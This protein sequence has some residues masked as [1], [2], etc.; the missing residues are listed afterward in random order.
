MSF[1]EACKH[2]RFG[3]EAG[4]KEIQCRRNAPSPV[5]AQYPSLHQLPVAVVLWPP[6]RP[7]DWCG[8]F[9]LDVD[10]F[11][12][13]ELESA[14]EFC[15]DCGSCNGCIG[16]HSIDNARDTCDDCCKAYG[17]D[18]DTVEICRPKGARVTVVDGKPETP[19]N[20]DEIV[21]CP[22]CDT[23]L[24]QGFFKQCHWCDGTGRLPR[25]LVAKFKL[26]SESK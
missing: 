21:D 12:E 16:D 20:L 25:W 26:V 22:M 4:E 9:E 17:H 19:E 15:T 14:D 6:M 7:T 5:S 8:D 23:Y 24:A 13:A 10:A 18:D 2:C 1:E 3:H 11:L